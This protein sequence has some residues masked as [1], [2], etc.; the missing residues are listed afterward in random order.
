MKNL[1]QF[2]YLKNC[3][4]KK[5]E[6]EDKCLTGELFPNSPV[7]GMATLKPCF[8]PALLLPLAESSPFPHLQFLVSLPS[9]NPWQPHEHP[10]NIPHSS[11]PTALFWHW[12][13]TDLYNYLSL[14]LYNGS[15]QL[16]FKFL[17]DTSHIQ[18]DSMHNSLT[19]K[20]D[21][22]NPLVSDDIWH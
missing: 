4:I 8:P 11:N 17:K 14:Y 9:R 10:T 16:N 2:I 5:N 1:P 7:A 12:K 13:G 3:H 19:P 6:F 18:C 21:H 22:T 15:H 20:Y